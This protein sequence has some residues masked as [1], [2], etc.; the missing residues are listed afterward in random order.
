MVGWG[1]V[2]IQCPVNLWAH[3][4]E[5]RGNV[6]ANLY[7]DHVQRTATTCRNQFYLFVMWVLR[8]SVQKSGSVPGTLTH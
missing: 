4:T 3:S 2:D 6:T 1:R 5:N 7:T 8:I